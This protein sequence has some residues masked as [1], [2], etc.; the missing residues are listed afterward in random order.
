MVKG[1]GQLVPLVQNLGQAHVRQ[2]Q[3]CCLAALADRGQCLPVGLQRR[4]QV[5]PGALHLAQVVAD[6]HGQEA[7]EEPGAARYGAENLRGLAAYPADRRVRRPPLGEHFCQ[8]GLGWPERPPC[9][10]AAAWFQRTKERINQ[11]SSPSWARAC[12]L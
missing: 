7:T 6:A 11:S 5:A 10:S 3:G 1:G 2:A 12:R 9:Q 8:A 4:I